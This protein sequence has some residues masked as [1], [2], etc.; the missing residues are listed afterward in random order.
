VAGGSGGDGAVTG[1]L[2]AEGVSRPG[3][4]QTVAQFVRP[5]G[6]DRGFV[7]PEPGLTFAEVLDHLDM[8]PLLER[9][10]R[11]TDPDVDGALASRPLD[12]TLEDFAILLSPA[13]S[14]RLPD[15][16]AASRALTLR[17]FGRTMHMYAPLYLSNECMTT[18]VYCGFARELPIA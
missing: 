14:V 2:E 13:A 15:L 11:A 8:D 12:R 10:R 16:A 17:R 18:C 4:A 1:E 6:R 3:S 9:S 5:P 7:P